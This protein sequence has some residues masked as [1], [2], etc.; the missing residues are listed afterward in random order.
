MMTKTETAARA[1]D[2]AK[3]AVGDRVVATLH[4]FSGTVTKVAASTITVM[5]DQ[6]HMIDREQ[7]F[8]GYVGEIKFSYRHQINK[9]RMRGFKLTK[10]GDY[11]DVA[12]ANL[13]IEEN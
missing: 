1:T 11:N 12:K 6:Q 8:C 2:R 9:F 5:P 7:G 13:A 4:Y 10:G 3:F